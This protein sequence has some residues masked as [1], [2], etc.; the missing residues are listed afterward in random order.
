MSL[1]RWLLLG[2]LVAALMERPSDGNAPLLSTAVFVYLGARE[3][4][5]LLGGRARRNALLLSGPIDLLAIGWMSYAL[6]TD[7]ASLYVVVVLS[8]ALVQGPG[9]TL[10]SGA[11]A[12]ALYVTGA[13]VR[14]GAAAA[15]PETWIH[16]SAIVISVALAAWLAEMRQRE[17]REGLKSLDAEKSRSDLVSLVSHELR[18]PLAMIKAAVDLL[19]DGGPGTVSA[20]QRTFLATISDS[21]ERLIGLVEDLL[22][23]A[24]VEAGKLRLQMAQVDARSPVRSAVHAFRPLAAKRRQTIHM[25]YPQVF[26][27]VACDEHWIYQVVVNLLSNAS[28]YTTEGGYIYVSVAENEFYVSV[29]VTDDGAGMSREERSRMFE[30]FFRG[31]HLGVAGTGLGLAIVQYVAEKHG[32]KV[33]VDTTLGRGTTFLFTLPKQATD[34]GAAPSAEPARAAPAARRSISSVMRWRAG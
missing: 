14:G 23:R 28:K 29:S 13:A 8:V 26:S 34:S 10:F 1:G 2:A 24:W 15:T 6:A 33:L 11:I 32:G 22:T 30:P 5:V 4:V 17:R 18:T 12:L 19:L 16:L 25:D 7:P 9:L 31:T 3:I 27:R 21:C 20:E